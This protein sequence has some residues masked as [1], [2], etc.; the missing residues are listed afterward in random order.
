MSES[1]CIKNGAKILIILFY[2]FLQ[3]NVRIVDVIQS[4]LDYS[5]VQFQ[6]ALSRL[7]TSYLAAAVLQE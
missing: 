3:V 7:I 1:R 4:F 6:R 2:F 5:S